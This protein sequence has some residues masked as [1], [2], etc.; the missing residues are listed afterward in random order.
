MHEEDQV[1]V[2][3]RDCHFN[4]KPTTV[5][6]EQTDPESQR[7]ITLR[8]Y[9]AKD[10]RF[11]VIHKSGYPFINTFVNKKGEPELVTKNTDKFLPLRPPASICT[12][13]EGHQ[14]LSC[15]S[16]HTSWSPQCIGCHTQYNPEEKGYDLL[17]GKVT[18]GR[19]DETPSGYLAGPPTLGIRITKDKN[20]KISET[21][22]TFIP[23]MILTIQKKDINPGASKNKDLIFRRMFAPTFS[24]TISKESRSCKSCHNNPFALGYGR[25][26]L[27]FVKHGKFGKWVFTPQYPPSKY[28]GLPL[29]AW[30][31]F[32]GTRESYYATRANVRPFNV[33]EQKNILT[34]GACLTCHLPDSKVMKLYLDKGKM[35]SPSSSCVLPEWE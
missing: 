31:P 34:A 24:H 30:I 13:G 27:E 9:N 3:C 14:N 22:D 17:N 18:K 16:C 12:E 7:I 21:V 20:G 6:I 26:K 4:G 2:T 10:R 8:K 11:L 19:W 29:D 35:P 28:D 25:G 33:Q 32:L 5:G 23:G 1:E 15:G